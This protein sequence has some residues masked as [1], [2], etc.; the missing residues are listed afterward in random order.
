VSRAILTVTEGAKF[1]G[2]EQRWFGDEVT[3]NNQANAVESGSVIT[4]SSLRGV[5]FITIGLWAVAGIICAVI[6]FRPRQEEEP[7]Q[8]AVAELAVEHVC[9]NRDESIIWRIGRDSHLL[10]QLRGNPP[11]PADAGAGALAEI[12]ICSFSC[13]VIHHGLLMQEL[14]EWHS[15][16]ELKEAGLDGVEPPPDAINLEAPDEQ[17]RLVE[18]PLLTAAAENDKS[19]EPRN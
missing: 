1:A 9:G 19:N 2:I 13:V 7:V 6:W 10:I 3:C 17:V 15:R 12:V 18:L 4:L 14:K 5:F 16:D 11:R 8:E